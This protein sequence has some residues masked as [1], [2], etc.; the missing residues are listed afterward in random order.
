LNGAWYIEV[1]DGWGSD[2]GYLFG[3]ELALTDEYATNVGFD[4]ASIVPEAPW[5]TTTSDT[6]FIMSPPASLE[7][8]TVVNC[9]LHFYDSDGCIFDS[10]VPVQ[11]YATY[12]E[13]T[14]VTVCDSYV[15]RS[16]NYTQSGDFTVHNPSPVGCDSIFSLH[17]TV[18]NSAV[19]D[20]VATE[21]G[22]FEWHGVEYT[23]TPATAPT[24]NYHTAWLAATAW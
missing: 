22:S 5:T 19:N 21:C 8:D 13:E 14:T 2:N 7:N 10:I 6:T 15:W 23:A 12:N 1:M 9:I 16:V 3:W 18:N 4:V 24:Y 11:V 17:L 20:T